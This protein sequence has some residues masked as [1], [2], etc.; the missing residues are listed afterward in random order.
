VTVASTVRPYPLGAGLQGH[1]RTAGRH[2][3]GERCEQRPLL[4]QG[5]QRLG[6]PLHADDEP[7]VGVLDAL[8]QAVGRPGDRAQ[9]L[10]QAV[11]G[12]V[13]ECVAMSG[14]PERQRPSTRSASASTSTASVGGTTTGTPPAC[15]IACG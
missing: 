15:A 13:V 7:L 12:L 14:P 6:V 4:R 3:S 11:D 1:G 9:A 8:D 5:A 10:A 2:G